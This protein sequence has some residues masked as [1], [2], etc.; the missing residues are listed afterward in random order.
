MYRI[1]AV[2]RKSVCL[3]VGSGSYESIA[4][5]QTGQAAALPTDPYLVIQ[6]ADRID[7][8]AIQW[9]G[10][11]PLNLAFFKEVQSASCGSEPSTI[12]TVHVN[13]SVVSRWQTGGRR[14]GQENTVLDS[15]Q[16]LT[17]AYPNVAFPVFKQC[18]DTAVPTQLLFL[19]ESH[20]SGVNAYETS[21]C[22][23]PSIRISIPQ[24]T[25]HLN[26]AECS[27]HHGSL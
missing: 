19:S 16:A 14:I 1:Y 27:W 20:A 8:I 2:L 25:Q 26:F 13:R 21:R 3:C 4:V 9:G 12:L 10:C 22:S 23:D 11:N 24:Q 17:T 18:I 6:S 7:H 5:L 15:L